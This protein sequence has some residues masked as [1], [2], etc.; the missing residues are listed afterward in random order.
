MKLSFE[1]LNEMF[2]DHMHDL[3]IDLNKRF[4]ENEIS[5]LFEN[6]LEEQCFKGNLTINDNT[7]EYYQL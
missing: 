1:Q 2:E 5:D 7:G 3:E 6:W 4:N